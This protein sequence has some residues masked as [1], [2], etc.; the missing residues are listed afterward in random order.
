MNWVKDKYR[1]IHGTFHASEVIL[2]ARIQVLAG[3]IWV[4]LQGVDVSPVISNPKYLVWWIIFSNLVN[5][6]LRRRRAEY[7]HDGNIK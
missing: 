6:A 7:D 5:E 3:V 2:W 1:Y 4:A